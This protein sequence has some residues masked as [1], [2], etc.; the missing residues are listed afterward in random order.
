MLKSRW[1]TILF[2][3]VFQYV[4]G[5]FTQ[6]EKRLHEPQ[7]V[8]LGDLGFRLMNV[9]LCDFKLSLFKI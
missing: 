9:I 8:P 1:K 2:G 4:H 3:V 7:V 6:L 5:I